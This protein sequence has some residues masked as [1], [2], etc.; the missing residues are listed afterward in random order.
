LSEYRDIADILIGSEYF[1][2]LE[3][4][5]RKKILDSF[6]YIYSIDTGWQ[7]VEEFEIP[8]DE[9]HEVIVDLLY[10][11]ENIDQKINELVEK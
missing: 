11:Y 8:I 3:N 1:L 7:Y 2:L 9:I 5:E 10:L 4:E 6:D